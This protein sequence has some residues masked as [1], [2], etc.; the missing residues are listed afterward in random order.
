MNDKEISYIDRKIAVLDNLKKDKQAEIDKKCGAELRQMDEYD[1]E[2]QYLKRMQKDI[3][4]GIDP[5]EP[6]P[7]PGP[8]SKK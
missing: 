5:A 7:K 6:K 3:L 8:K 4:S 1:R 2:I